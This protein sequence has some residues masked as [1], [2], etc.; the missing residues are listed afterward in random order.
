M[1]AIP[2]ALQTKFEEHLRMESGT[3]SPASPRLHRGTV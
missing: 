1:L 3:G 2:S